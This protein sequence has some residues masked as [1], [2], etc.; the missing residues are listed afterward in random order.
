MEINTKLLVAF[1]KLR[2]IKFKRKSAIAV[3]AV[4]SECAVILWNYVFG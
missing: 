2:M 1:K 3:A 4:F